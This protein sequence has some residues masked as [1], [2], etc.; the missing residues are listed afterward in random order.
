MCCSCSCAA[1][2]SCAVERTC[3]CQ[4]AA[5]RIISLLRHSQA[6][7]PFPCVSNGSLAHS[8][9]PPRLPLPPL[10]LLLLLMLHLIGPG[11]GARSSRSLRIQYC[12]I[13][14]VA[15]ETIRAAVAVASCAT[16]RDRHAPR[17]ATLRDDTR[18]HA[19]ASCRKIITLSAVA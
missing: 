9:S 10:P 12:T 14:R 4:R 6:V 15:A 17:H 1:Q 7:S 5:Q 16:P 19:P 13:Y 11:H 8:C 18:G 3:A 2:S